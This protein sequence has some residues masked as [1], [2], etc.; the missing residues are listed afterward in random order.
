VSEEKQYLVTDLT[1]GE[2]QRGAGVASVPKD[3]NDSARV[4]HFSKVIPAEVDVCEQDRV[5]IYVNGE[6]LAVLPEEWGLKV[7]KL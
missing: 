1:G 6:P 7:E 2:V 3:I 4:G 5:L